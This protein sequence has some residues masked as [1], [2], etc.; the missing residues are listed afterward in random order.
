MCAAALDLF[1]YWLFIVISMYIIAFW[2][3]VTWRDD[4]GRD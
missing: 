1:V 4:G 3:I 2:I